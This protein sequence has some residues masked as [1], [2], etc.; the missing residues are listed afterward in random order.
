[1]IETHPQLVITGRDPS[2]GGGAVDPRALIDAELH[3]LRVMSDGMGG[4]VHANDV[5]VAE[6]IRDM[7]LP[8]DPKR[9]WRPGA[10]PQR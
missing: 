6:G 5:R 8:A 7:E 4:M 2:R 9:P 1:M 10:D 3:Y